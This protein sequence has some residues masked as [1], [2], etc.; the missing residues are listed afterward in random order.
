MKLKLNILM[1]DYIIKHRKK[2]PNLGL[3]GTLNARKYGLN[4]F[5]KIVSEVSSFVGNP[6]HRK[7]EIKLKFN[8]SVWWCT[9]I[10][11]LSVQF[12]LL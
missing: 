11:T 1:V 10:N 7:N 6:V 3:H 5:R 2:K 12:S 9:P 8:S 4:K